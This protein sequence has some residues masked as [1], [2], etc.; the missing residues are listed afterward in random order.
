MATLQ[1]LGAYELK[2]VGD[3]GV[4]GTRLPQ[5]APRYE[6]MQASLHRAEQ[7]V[8]LVVGRPPG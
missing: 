7:T 5:P 4:S 1:S 6:P 3:M 2:P 8:H